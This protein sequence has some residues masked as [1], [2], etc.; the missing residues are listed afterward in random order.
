MPRH[1]RKQFAGAKYHAMNRGNG[2]QRVF[3]AADDYERFLDQLQDALA[4]DQV[5]LYAYCLMPNHFHLFVETPNANIDE[6]MA[7][8]GTAYGM[9]FRYKHYRPGHCFQG[10]YKAPLV[11]GDDYILRLTRYIHLN[12]VKTPANKGLPPGKKWQVLLRHRWS[13]LSGYLRKA[14]AE[15]FI[16]YRW[17]SMFGSKRTQRARYG[18]YVRMM[19]SDDDP[20]LMESTAS[21]SYA[22]GDER[23]RK[24]VAEWVKACASTAPVPR[25]LAMPPEARVPL[26]AVAQEVA[27]AFGFAPDALKAPRTRFGHGRGVFVE[28]ACRIGRCSQRDVARYL[29]CVSEHG[30]GKARRNL[31]REMSVNPA[32]AKELDAIAL[33]LKAKV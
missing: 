7:R 28:L 12:P 14:A 32:L 23:F 16:D 2:K 26:D 1:L 6:F 9:Y 3:Y 18:A 21:S 11:Q 27:T 15:E 5:L 30:V 31:R 29:G 8:L 17:L 22:I 13:S 33:R 19:L 10:R 24:E 20:V 4:K 25:D